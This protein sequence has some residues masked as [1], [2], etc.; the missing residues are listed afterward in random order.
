M[1]RYI[2]AIL[3]LTATL[4]AACSKDTVTEQEFASLEV[5]YTLSGAEVRALPV[6]SSSH[7]ITVDV[8]LNNQSIY[9]DVESDAEWCSVVAE[10]H[11]GSGAFTVN[12][13]ANEEFTDREPATLTFIAGQ[14]RGH[15]L[16]VTQTGNIF[17]VS[18]IYAIG[19][20]GEGSA[21][22]SVA[23]VEGI[24]WDVIEQPWLKA[25]KG[26][27]SSSD[28]MVTTAL[29]ITW[30]ANTA[31]SR[32]G[33]IGLCRDGE[34]QAEAQFNVFQFG[35]ELPYEGEGEIM[36]PS[37]DATSLEVKTPAGCVEAVA[38]P[39]WVSYTV[40]ENGD[41]TTSYIFVTEDNPSDTRTIRTS[42][43][44][45]KIQDKEGAVALPAIKQQYYPVS[46][47]TSA[48]GLKL[49]AQT[50]NA[51]G[52][53]SDW[54][55][56]GKIVLLNNIDMSK[57]TGEW[58]P[59][60]NAAHKFGEEFDG[61][62][63]KIMN[64]RSSKPL[65][66]ECEG[67]KLKAIIID[68][69]SAFSATDEYMTEYTL[70]P[71]ADRLTA[72]TVAECSNYAPVVMRAVTNNTATA[73]YVSGLVGRVEAGTTIDK[74]VNYGAVSATD[75]CS[76]AVQQGTFNVAGI[77]AVNNGTLSAC[78]NQGTVGDGAVSY[79]HFVGGITAV[80]TG[81]VS[82]CVNKGA[83]NVASIRVVNG[84]LD[85][86]RYIWL[87]GI[88]GQNHGKIVESTN[89]AAIVSTSDVKMQR[90]GGVAGALMTENPI[91]S[92]NKNTKN[93]SISMNGT[94][95]V[96]AGVRVLSL[97]GLYGEIL[98]PVTFDF[99]SDQSSSEGAI[100]CTKLEPSSTTAYIY[101]GGLIGWA[102]PTGRVTLIKPRWEST[103]TFDFSKS[104]GA[105]FILGV[106]GIIGGADSPIAIT[107]AKTAGAISITANTGTTM[108]NKIA[109]LGGVIGYAKSDVDIK[110]C[111]NDASV[112]QLIACAKSNSY[113]QFIGGIVGINFTVIY[114]NI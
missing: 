111:V 72:C 102:T 112:Q 34:T 68:E 14:F 104:A 93:G 28:G 79:N 66:G 86:S 29:H 64:F 97:G 100:S 39:A 77:A 26:T 27:S 42:D 1:K 63:R 25:Q 78:V 54:K 52:D 10:N 30:D 81:E 45:I 87:G 91:L 8:T 41:N 31:A 36:L 50:V 4:A 56:D 103:I 109:A 43:I 80:S 61:A 57:L 19:A 33:Q 84:V 49:F 51:G 17:I 89:D 48:D 73:A 90:V 9:W 92:N 38:A 18:Q 71:L 107:D 76:T 55:K 105:L 5:G 6:N 70:A 98:M 22:V 24:E 85:Y 114:R 113:P 65:F 108:Q 94:N 67:A 58:T 40:R 74:C 2:Y 88:V 75:E 59:I 106:G 62:Y 37:K 12:I 23:V 3:L 96:Q 35:D 46:G 69:T 15:T 60:G 47:I 13:K 110:R 21:D 44:S 7:N 83:I 16:K 20:K 11:R 101:V 82:A 99:T 53:T 32:Y 95:T